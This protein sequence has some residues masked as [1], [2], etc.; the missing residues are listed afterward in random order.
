VQLT[1]Q[2]IF[3]NLAQEKNNIPFFEAQISVEAEGAGNKITFDQHM[4]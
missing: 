3:I 4:H 1:L 2:P